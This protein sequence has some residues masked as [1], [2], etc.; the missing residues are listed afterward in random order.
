MLFQHGGQRRELRRFQLG[1]IG[2]VAKHQIATG[3]EPVIKLFLRDL[4]VV[5]C[6]LDQ[7]CHVLRILHLPGKERELM[8]QPIEMYFLVDVGL[9]GL[10]L[11]DIQLF[12]FH[13]LIPWISFPPVPLFKLFLTHI[14]LKLSDCLY[15]FFI[16]F[17]ILLH[18]CCIFLA[19]PVG[20]GTPVQP[21]PVQPAQLGFAPFLRQAVKGDK[22]PFFF[23]QIH[24]IGWVIPIQAKMLW[25]EEC[26]LQ[27]PIL[28]DTSQIGIILTDFPS[29]S[30]V[31]FFFSWQI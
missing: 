29:I 10:F 25:Q 2:P 9:I 15:R 12:L 5:L 7:V 14:P 16:A 30:V 21:L 1:E 6:R 11:D 17:Q 13:I 24:F 19:D 18:S 28:R 20:F 22:L 31:R 3:N 4:A 26:Y 27:Y 8:E 23:I